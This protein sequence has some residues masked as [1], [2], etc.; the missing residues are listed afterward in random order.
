MGSQISQISADPV[1]ENRAED[2]G[3]DAEGDV[4]IIKVKVDGADKRG[5]RGEVRD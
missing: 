2:Y 5:A 1:V 3:F 4:E